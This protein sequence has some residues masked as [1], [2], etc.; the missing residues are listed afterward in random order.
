MTTYARRLNSPDGD[1]GPRPR[2]RSL[3]AAVAQRTI[4]P[5]TLAAVCA[6][7]PR[8]SASSAISAVLRAVPRATSVLVRDV[9]QANF[10]SLCDQNGRAILHYDVGFPIA[11]NKHTFPHAFPIDATEK[12]PIVLSHWDWDHLHGAFHLPHLLDCIWIVPDQL[13]GPGA[14]R[15]ARILAA[16]GKLLV[17][18]HKAR[19]RFIFGEIDSNIGVVNNINNTG[20]SILVK[21]TNGRTVLLTGDADYAYLGHFSTPIVDHLIATHHGAYFDPILNSVPTP[22]SALSKLVISCGTGNVYRHP[23]P[24]ALVT[25]NN[26]GW[27]TQIRTSGQKGFAQRGD[28]ILQ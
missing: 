26:A 3:G 28:K 11:F 25:H 15:L 8:P 5:S 13:I 16:R 22:T 1:F 4:L 6:T 7:L 2:Y 14:T 18:P 27:T 12:P 23:H 20:L 19:K 24:E 17:R 10:S 21:L 9:G